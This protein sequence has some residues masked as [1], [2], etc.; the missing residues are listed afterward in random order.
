MHRSKTQFSDMM[1]RFGFK[2]PNTYV[3]FVTENLQRNFLP[4]R[5]LSY[6]D[7]P[8]V[9]VTK[10]HTFMHSLNIDML[11]AMMQG[12]YRGMVNFCKIKLLEG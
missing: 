6:K 8:L 1:I 3:R 4:I 2:K 11:H 9:P 5:K 12:I 7:T 10:Q